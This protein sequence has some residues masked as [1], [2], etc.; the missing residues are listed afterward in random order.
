MKRRRKPTRIPRDQRFVR[1]PFWMLD[2]DAY[3]ELTGQSVKLITRLGMRFTG[4]NNGAI[5]MSV[6]EAERELDCCR[7]HAAKCFRELEQAGFIRPTQRGSFAWKK[8][9]A[10]TWRL[11]WLPASGVGGEEIEASKEFMRADRGRT[12]TPNAVAQDGPIR[13]TA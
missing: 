13:R 9:H 11:T 6:R 7:N 10:T 3:R 5:A 12:R 2:S 4:S 1:L 8:R